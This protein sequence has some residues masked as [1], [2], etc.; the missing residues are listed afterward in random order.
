MRLAVIPARGGSKRIPR[1]NIKLFGGQPMIAW[2]IQAAK[3]SQCFDRI[4]VSTDD[5]EIAETAIAYGAEVPFMRP[6]ELSG[7]HVATTPVIA[8][9]IEWQNT[10][11]EMVTEACCIY[12]TTPFMRPEDL[13]LGLQT[14]KDTGGNYAFSVTSFAYPIQ[15][16][17]RVT[18]NQRLA[19]IQPEYYGKRTQ[20]L[21]PTLHDAGQFYWGTATAW[22]NNEILFAETSA[23]VVL[24]R[25]L[26]HDLD[27]MED[28]EEAEIFWEYF[29]Q[30]QKKNKLALGAAQFGID[31]GVSNTNGKVEIEEVKRIFSVAR[32]ANIN[33]LDTA[34]DYGDSEK[35]IGQIGSHSWNIVTK[36]P[37]V[38]R[39]CNDVTGWVREQLNGSLARLK[40]PQVYGLLLHRPSQLLEDIGPTLF[41]ALKT[42]QSE[43]L[44]KK[45]GISIYR[46]TTLE[47]ILHQYAIDLVQAPLNIIDRSFVESGWVNRLSLAGV[48]VHVRSVFLQGLL[49]M[50][51][52]QR[53]AKFGPWAHIWAEWD[54][55]LAESGLTP[56]QACLRYVCGLDSIDRVVVGVDS[57]SQLDEILSACN[58]VLDSLPAFKPLQD[59]RLINP[60]S[61]DQL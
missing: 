3:Q 23:P 41:G 50:P 48:E 39:E 18:S 54:R 11:G 30:R 53:P 35:N 45:I 20:D 36:L 44:V 29:K 42:V 34:I 51:P 55:W 12:P 22:L 37:P 46:H 32:S 25:H 2:A 57:V 16:A 10:H 19:M 28:W 17:L 6:S 52:S 1:K 47:T 38:P 24:P 58:G 49:L 13:I 33:T 56:L 9:A 8:H 4:I 14:L 31:Y 59:E 21:E 60:A 43:G 61:W 5:Q 26:V 40:A 15:R 7:D 27:T